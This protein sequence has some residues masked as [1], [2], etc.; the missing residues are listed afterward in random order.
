[1]KHRGGEPLR[2]YCRSNTEVA[3]VK[4]KVNELVAQAVRIADEQGE[5]K[6]SNSW[7][8]QR[9][10][11]LERNWRRLELEAVTIAPSI[12]KAKELLSYQASVSLV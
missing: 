12:A 2:I 1:M 4:G 5:N 8:R 6:S 3:S 11:D 10:D 7:L 9:R